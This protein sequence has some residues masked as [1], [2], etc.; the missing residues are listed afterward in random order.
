MTPRGR[1]WLGRFALILGGTSIGLLLAEVAVRVMAPGGG[2]FVL[3]AGIG[4]IPADLYQ[5]DPELRTRLRPSVQVE[6]ESLEY[7][8]QIRT[9]SLGIRGPEVPRKSSDEIRILTVGDSFTLGI[10]VA[11]DETAG[12]QL[13]ARLSSA[14]GRE[15]TTWNAGVDGY[16]TDQATELARQ[17]AR[18]IDADILLLRFYLGNDLRDN[19]LWRHPE[20]SSA[21]IE[22]EGGPEAE[23]WNHIHRSLAR[24]SRLYAHVLAW[25][26]ARDQRSDPR[27]QEMA[28]ELLPYVNMERLEA[29]LPATQAALQRTAA[30]CAQLEI[31]CVV[32]WAPPAHVVHPERA[33]ATF[34]IFELDAQLSDPARLLQTV[35]SVLPRDTISCDPGPAL[36][37]AAQTDPLYFVFDPHWNPMGHRIAGQADADCLMTALNPD[38]F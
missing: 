18:E 12:A 22:L 10:Q 34:D 33:G 21:P 17:L 24:W 15:V 3:E 23:D 9:N 11:E 1:Q 2:E 35:Q 13:A 29:L 8:S 32:S 6:H 36:Q 5:P 31:P 20:Q 26:I 19:Q 4:T 7:R 28:D 27:I 30:L 14:W 38:S 16:G 37:E 25:K